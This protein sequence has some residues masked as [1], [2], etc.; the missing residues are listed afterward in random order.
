[1]MPSGVTVIPAEAIGFGVDDPPPLRLRHVRKPA[2]KEAAVGGAGGGR[3]WRFDGGA[4]R[5]SDALGEG[6]GGGST[7]AAGRAFPL[8]FSIGRFRRDGRHSIGI[9]RPWRNG[10][11]APEASSGVFSLKP[12]TL[13]SSI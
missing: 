1:M 13:M 5:A 8:L 7:N 9:P 4:A 12:R 2:G 11:A 6:V 10:A 3:L